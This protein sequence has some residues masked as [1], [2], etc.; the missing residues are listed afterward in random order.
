MRTFQLD[1]PM[2]KGPVDKENE[3]KSLWLER[4][5]MTISSP[6]PGIFYISQWKIKKSFSRLFSF[7][8]LIYELTK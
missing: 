3:F 1:R 2:H 7:G 4:T 8:S 6:L 5:L